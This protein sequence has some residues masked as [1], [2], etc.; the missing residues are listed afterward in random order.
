M[1]YTL[2]IYWMDNNYKSHNITEYFTTIEKC[3]EVYL[4]LSKLFDH[5]MR[6]GKIKDYQVSIDTY[7]NM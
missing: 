7:K 5:E 3:K 1:K 6:K 2:T 4:Y